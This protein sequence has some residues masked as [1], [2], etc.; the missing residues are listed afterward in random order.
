MSTLGAPATHTTRGTM[1]SPNHDL[2]G[3]CSGP[4]VTGRYEPSEPGWVREHVEQLMR[5]GT[6]DGLTIQGLS[7]VLM[8][9]QGAKTGKVRKTP[10]MRVE[11]GSA[12]RPSRPGVAR[13]PTRSRT[14][15][16]SPSQSSSFKDGGDPGST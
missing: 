11:H 1:E 6:T 14:Q 4:G 12:T 8:T 2:P 16:W 10:V 9:Y 5:T 15:A 3:S 13:R 7:T